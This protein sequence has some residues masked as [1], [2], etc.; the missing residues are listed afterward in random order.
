MFF[1]CVAW[2]R[3]ELSRLLVLSCACP[4]ARYRPKEARRRTRTATT[5]RRARRLSGKRFPQILPQRGGDE[6]SGCTWPMIPG[7][8]T[9][10]GPPTKG[11]KSFAS[12]VHGWIFGC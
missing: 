2:L 10:S 4:A 8:R 11:T 6:F 5:G 1:I 3:L 12:M 9:Q 7:A